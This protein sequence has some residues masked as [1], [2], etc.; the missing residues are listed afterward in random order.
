MI[1]LQCRDG[2]KVYGMKGNGLRFFDWG[3]IVQ[4]WCNAGDRAFK[5]MQTISVRFTFLICEP[6]NQ[7]LTSVA[8]CNASHYIT[9]CSNTVWHCDNILLLWTVFSECYNSVFVSRR[10]TAAPQKT[11]AAATPLLQPTQPTAPAAPAVHSRAAATLHSLPD[12]SPG[13]DERNDALHAVQPVSAISNIT[14]VCY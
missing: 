2:R 11:S 8:M 6:T 10:P 13:G 5:L 3:D 7:K 9:P 14:N 4:E 1:K 12:Q